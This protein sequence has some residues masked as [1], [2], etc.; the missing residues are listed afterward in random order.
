MKTFIYFDTEFT[1]PI[2]NTDLMSI[3]IT[4]DSKRQFY[5]EL[6]DYD[7]NK[8]PKE[9]QEWLKRNVINKFMLSKYS[10]N[11]VIHSTDGECETTFVKGD[12]AFVRKELWKWLDVYKRGIQLVSDCACYDLTLLQSLL[13][14]NPVSL[15][16]DFIQLVD[17][18]QIIMDVFDLDGGQAADV[19][20]AKL[21]GIEGSHNALTDAIQIKTIFNKLTIEDMK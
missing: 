15:S 13:T 2:K 9:S 18:N 1:A 6:T 16:Y 21:S 8:A 14:D 3:G 19:S 5:A 20:R 11:K 12:T 7:L 10:G 17:L 4:T